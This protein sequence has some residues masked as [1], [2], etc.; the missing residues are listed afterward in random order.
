MR[1]LR[2]LLLCE[3][4]AASKSG[5]IGL[6][7]PQT[8]PGTSSAGFD[9]KQVTCG[10]LLAVKHVNDGD[11]S[12]I[13]SLAAITANLTNLTGTLYDTGFSASTAI[14]SYRQ[15]KAAGGTAMVAAARSAVSRPLAL[16]GEVDKIPQ[17]PHG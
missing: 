9:W 2:L 6:I 15:M 13:P 4:V 3:V 16:L 14:V 17:V 8:K 1:T 7:I 11:E 12:V 10:A 5:S